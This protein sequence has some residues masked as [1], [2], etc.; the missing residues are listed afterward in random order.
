MS[1]PTARHQNQIKVKGVLLS[2]RV[3]DNEKLTTYDIP[4]NHEIYDIGDLCPVSQLIG[5]P[6]LVYKVTPTVLPASRQA[7]IRYQFSPRL[8]PNHTAQKLMIDCDAEL[9]HRQSGELLKPTEGWKD[10]VGNVIVVRK[11]RKPLYAHHVRVLLDFMD[12]VIYL[13]TEVRP[14]RRRMSSNTASP[15]DII[16]QLT[17]GE[18]KD[19]YMTERYYWQSE[20]YGPSNRASLPSPW[21]NT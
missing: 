9:A 18:F 19:F 15:L 20:P 17:P 10:T 16:A 5:M 4:T 13:G 11:D 12:K 1:E 6:L 3:G 2:E 14:G 21:T 8:Y 7:G